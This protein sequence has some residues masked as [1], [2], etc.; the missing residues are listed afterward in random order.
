MHIWKNLEDLIAG[1]FEMENMEN[2]YSRKNDV[3][4]NKLEIFTCY[5]FSVLAEM[6]TDFLT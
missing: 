2:K 5:C 4:K 1:K 6:K 3:G